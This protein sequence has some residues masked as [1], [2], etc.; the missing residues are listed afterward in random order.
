MIEPYPKVE[1]LSHGNMALCDKNILK[2]VCR[3]GDYQ[4]DQ[5]NGSIKVVW[6]INYKY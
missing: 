6:E 2:C 1:T 5:Y 3:W 4:G